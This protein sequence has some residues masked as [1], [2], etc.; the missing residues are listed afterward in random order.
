MRRKLFKPKKVLRLPDKN[1]QTFAN[2]L[3]YFMKFSWL[4]SLVCTPRNNTGV[5]YVQY[6]KYDHYRPNSAHIFFIIAC[7]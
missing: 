7:I 5:P 1:Q 4:F 6:C 3:V 2:I